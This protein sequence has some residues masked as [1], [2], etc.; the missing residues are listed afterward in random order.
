[1]RSAAEPAAARRGW[2]SVLAPIRATWRGWLNPR[3]PFAA[4]RWRLLA[5]NVLVLA[6]IVL[7][8]GAA[9][10]LTVARIQ[11]DE[12]DQQLKLT[13]IQRASRFQTRE[14]FEHDDFAADAPGVF[15]IVSDVHRQILFNSRLVL[16]GFPSV[17]SLSMALDG[18]DN[19]QTVGVGGATFRIYSTPLIDHGQV[20]GAI[21]TGASL[22]P[23]QRELRDLLIIMLFGGLGGI[24][25]ATVGGLFLVELALVPARRAFVRQ[26][27]FVADASHELRT[28]IALIK[29]TAEVIARDPSQPVG[30]NAELLSDIDRET[31]HLGRLIDDLLQLARLD[32]G[33]LRAELAPVA[34]SD[35][36]R[37][38]V[39]QVKR[40]DLA[41][42][43]RLIATG[44]ANLWVR[45]DL[46]RLRQVML[47]LLD[48]AVKHT[49]PG[50]RITVSL[51]SAHGWNRVSVSDTG[52]GIA[53]EHLPQ[54]FERFYRVDKARS[55]ADG[56]AGLGLAIARE[57][58]EIQ[59]GRI[60]VESV[61]G[62]SSTF[63]IWLPA[64]KP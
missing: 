57:L 63:T 53:A 40:L 2:P 62:Q 7:V 11:A 39:E 16:P 1:M 49:P 60:T 52:E 42:D 24:A 12:V 46:G 3:D 61:L 34:L 47:I 55:R 33:Q 26:Q 17:P 8:V 28:P 13:A 9:V 56:G 59:G 48:N 10:Y 41:H 58:V 19:F 44:D 38:A 20:V 31:D 32:S 21:Q 54:I 5:W 22:A 64:T 6:L 45:G 30:A 51:Q 50:G 4:T 27:Q 15:V 14:R 35:V 43:L 18:Q 23:Q 29:A 36:A 37:E 25:L